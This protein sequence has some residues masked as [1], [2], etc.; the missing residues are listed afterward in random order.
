MAIMP[1][2]MNNPN[3]IDPFKELV[4]S[5]LADYEAKVAPESWEIKWHPK[6]GKD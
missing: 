2:I 6:V 5:K 1:T 3:N 4:K